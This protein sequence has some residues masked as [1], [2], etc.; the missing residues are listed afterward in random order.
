MDFNIP[1]IFNRAYFRQRRLQT[2]EIREQR[3]ASLVKPM[4]QPTQVQQTVLSKGESPN[5]VVFHMD[6][7]PQE[8]I[9]DALPVD[10]FATRCEAAA[11]LCRYVSKKYAWLHVGSQ[12]VGIVFTTICSYIIE[13][14][15]FWGLSIG[16]LASLLLVLDLCFSWSRLREK[17]SQLAYTFSRMM[18][19]ILPDREVRFAQRKLFME[20]SVLSSDL[21]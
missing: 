8:H 3:A 1:G 16:I 6:D 7:E 19:S 2:K 14:V 15:Y 21:D 5:V 11:R 13:E 12:F 4:V 18:S 20:S 10:D 9:I 17:Y